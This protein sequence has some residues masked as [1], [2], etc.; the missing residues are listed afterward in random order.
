[1]QLPCALKLVQVFGTHVAHV[2]LQ[3]P[4]QLEPPVEQLAVRHVVGADAADVFVHDLLETLKTMDREEIT[5]RYG[6]GNDLVAADPVVLQRLIDR[7]LEVAI[8]LFADLRLGLPHVVHVLD[9][10]LGGDPAFRERP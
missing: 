10:G 4:Q 6:P 5:R 7:L 8:L 2:F 1:V 9:R 3:H